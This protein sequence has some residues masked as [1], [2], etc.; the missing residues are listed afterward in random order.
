MLEWN[1]EKC[2]CGNCLPYWAARFH[3]DEQNER[4]VG[5]W[6]ILFTGIGTSIIQHV[7]EKIWKIWKY[8]WGFVSTG[9]WCSECL[10]MSLCV[11][12]FLWI[13]YVFLSGRWNRSLCRIKLCGFRQHLG[14]LWH[15]W[16][17]V[18]QCLLAGFHQGTTSWCWNGLVYMVPETQKWGLAGSWRS[19]CGH[20]HSE[21]W[22]SMLYMLYECLGTAGQQHDLMW[23]WYSFSTMQYGGKH[24]F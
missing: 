19:E 23:N 12:D 10:G 16:N 24:G 21:R 22:L 17:G 11:S 4:K 14:L 2:E 5:L 18:L 6:P 20:V 9:L 1:C 15:V 3:Q 8:Y 13:W 7:P